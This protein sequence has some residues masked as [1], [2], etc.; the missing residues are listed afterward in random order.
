MATRKSNS[1]KS[2]STTKT[3]KRKVS[4]SGQKSGINSAVDVSRNRSVNIREIEN[5]FI[6]REE[7]QK[8]TGKNMTWQ[9]KEYYSP[10]EPTINVPSKSSFSLTKKG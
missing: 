9:T 7:I 4:R 5:G 2:S 3:T 6:V 10:K 8:G 1:K